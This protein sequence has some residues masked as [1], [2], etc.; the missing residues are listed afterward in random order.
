MGLLTI[1]DF[2]FVELQKASSIQ[3]GFRKCETH[4]RMLSATLAH[5]NSK[6]EVRHRGRRKEERS[7]RDARNKEVP[8]AL[9]INQQARSM[10]PSVTEMLVLKCTQKY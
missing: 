5:G 7:E 9:L 3:Y 2:S 10:L 1:I 6:N 8:A 4:S